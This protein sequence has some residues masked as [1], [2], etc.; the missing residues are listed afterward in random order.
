MY[1][2]NNNNDSDNNKALDT[3]YDLNVN[4]IIKSSSY[5]SAL[6]L[7]RENLNPS[8]SKQGSAE[9]PYF[10]IPTWQIC[11][12][13]LANAERASGKTL[14]TTND[15]GKSYQMLKSKTKIKPII[16]TPIDQLSNSSYCLIFI[17]YIHQL[18]NML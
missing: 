10:V 18:I 2:D 15:N 17:K 13:R 14:Q 7:K 11:C 4:R 8:I 16:H 5:N 3:K 1:I 9:V 12:L 6:T